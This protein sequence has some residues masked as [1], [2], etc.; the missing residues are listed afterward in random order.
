MLL[1]AGML[2]TSCF[3]D[4]INDVDMTIGP[5][6]DLT[7]PVGST[8]SIYLRNIIE[9]DGVI[10]EMDDGTYCV[11]SGGPTNHTSIE[12]GNMDIE[13]PT[14]KD[15]DTEIGLQDF[16]SGVRGVQKAG[17]PNECSYVIDEN[18]ANYYLL[19]E[20][21]SA[22]I[23]DDVISVSHVTCYEN[24][25]TMTLVVSGFNSFVTNVWIK[26]FKLR[27]PV[28]FEFSDPK[29]MGERV[30]RRDGNDLMLTDNENGRK[31]EVKNGQL[32]MDFE[33]TFTGL[34]TGDRF[35]F[36]DQKIS[37]QRSEISVGGTFCIK[38]DDGLDMTK[39]TVAELQKIQA[40]GLHSVLAE[41][42]T[43]NGP[44]RF[45]NNFVMRRFSG[46]LQYKIDDVDPIKLEDLPDFLNDKGVVLDLDN[47]MFLVNARYEFA[48]GLR[49][50]ITLTSKYTDASR[51]EGGELPSPVKKETGN[52]TLESHNGS[53]ICYFAEKEATSLPSEYPGAKWHKVE[54]LSDL[55]W[56]IPD[57][58]TIDVAPVSMNANDV[59]IKDYV[60]DVDY[61]VYAPLAFGE[62]F[63]LVYSGTETGLAEDFEDME[64]VEDMDVSLNVKADIK[65]D[66]KAGFTLTLIPL[67]KDGNQLEDLA[68]VEI[69]YVP[70]Q[71]SNAVDFGLTPQHGKKVSDI[72]LGRNGAKQLDGIK[73]VAR[74]ENPVVGE[75]LSSSNNISLHNIKVRIKGKA[76]IDVDE[77]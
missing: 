28:D 77:M 72:L 8:G 46:E 14:I 66:L 49:T 55:V 7:I 32:T 24:K 1:G 71:T 54:G 29:F 64:D 35:I 56:K 26:G 42:I 12:I 30:L 47:P 61:E 3:E 50:A 15:I 37:F 41:K 34:K 63:K 38:K 48:A 70:G 2:V 57:E 73:Y 18:K 65:S 53:A 10:Q 51:F 76:S 74:I 62:K 5:S 36:K 68:A 20:K 59:E 27:M 44:A 17:I 25:L 39:L 19:L 13:K 16:F 9:T 45:A 6:I 69:N 33:V 22:T 43:M 52:V 67:D 58:I 11:R 75:A 21:S 23:P 31:F 60:V 4:D 40:E